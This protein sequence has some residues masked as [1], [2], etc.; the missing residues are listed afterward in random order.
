MSRIVRQV[1]LVLG[2]A[3]ASVPTWA[4]DTTAAKAAAGN[5]KFVIRTPEVTLE[6]LGSLEQE[7]ERI[8]GT[9]AAPT[10]SVPVHGTMIG[11][12]LTLEFALHL[13]DGDLPV[14][15]TGTLGPTGFAGHATLGRLG[16][17]EWTGARVQ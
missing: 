15:M 17:G 7:A 16:E 3:F 6:V 14:H 9:I 11:D 5:W 13:P 12:E 4:Q 10:G 8:I 1:I 2:I